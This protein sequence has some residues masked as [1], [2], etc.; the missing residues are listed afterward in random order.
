MKFR[1]KVFDKLFFGVFIRFIMEGYIEFFLAVL[2]NLTD[3]SNV[4]R[5]NDV[6]C[7][8]Q[9]VG[10]SPPALFCRS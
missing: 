5:L 10:R 9:P 1:V 7:G 4:S 3:V 2:L 8:S 6:R